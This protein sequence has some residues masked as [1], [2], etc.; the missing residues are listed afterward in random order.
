MKNITGQDSQSTLKQFVYALNSNQ[1]LL[2]LTNMEDRFDESHDGKSVAK[3]YTVDL[4]QY[5]TLL[6]RQAN[7]QDLFGNSSAT[8]K[9]TIE[10]TTLTGITNYK[11]RMSEDTQWQTREP[12][13]AAFK[14]QQSL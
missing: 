12:I 6:Y 13:T 4:K 9:I 10:E 8:P 7:D 1:V 14:S 2:R 11:K 5:A 3:N